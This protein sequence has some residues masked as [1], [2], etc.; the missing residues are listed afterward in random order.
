MLEKI[1]T[2]TP[3]TGAPVDALVT[4][5]EMIPPGDRAKLMPDEAAGAVTA[6]GVPLVAA[7]ELFT[8]EIFA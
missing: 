8:H 2:E 7:H 6:I 5:P 1:V 3:D 4:V